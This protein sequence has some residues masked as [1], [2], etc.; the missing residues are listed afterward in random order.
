V[1][2]P[3]A[4]LLG[5]ELDGGVGALVDDLEF[6]FAGRSGTAQEDQGEEQS[7]HGCHDPKRCHRLSLSK[8]RQRR[9][10]VLPNR[11]RFNKPQMGRGPLFGRTVAH[12][13]QSGPSW[14]R[15][16]GSRP[17]WLGALPSVTANSGW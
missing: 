17:R 2:A 4:I 11:N 14:S 12:L 16:H 6:P 13:R 8:F 5:A 1:A 7:E 3:L 15:N 9:L 10:P